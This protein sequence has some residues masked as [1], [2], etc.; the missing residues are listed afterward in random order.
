MAA[1]TEQWQQDCA[2]LADLAQADADCR[3]FSRLPEPFITPRLLSPYGTDDGAVRFSFAH[4]SGE[5]VRVQLSAADF[6]W[7]AVAGFSILFPWAFRGWLAGVCVW[8]INRHARIHSSRSSGM[9]RADGSP[10]DGQA[11]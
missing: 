2:A 5:V 4:E 11:Q 10:K 1:H 8:A 3:R 9:P 6:C 7:L